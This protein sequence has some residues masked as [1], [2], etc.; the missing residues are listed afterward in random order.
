MGRP[1]ATLSEVSS[2]LCSCS[3]EHLQPCVL[4]A[5]TLRIRA[6][7]RCVRAAAPRHL[8]GHRRRREQSQ[9]EGGAQ[10]R[11]RRDGR[12]EGGADEGA[13]RVA[14]VE[15]D[16]HRVLHAEEEV[17]APRRE[18]IA[19][20]DVVSEAARGRKHLNVDRRAREA[21]HAPR[22]GDLQDLR[23]LH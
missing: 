13:A 16:D 8:S 5:A 2:Q 1:P 6:T 21:G 15:R 12:E 17:L 9:V 10:R 20:P 22:L 19:E 23:Q 11:V 18:R 3:A 14:E 7:P 4:E